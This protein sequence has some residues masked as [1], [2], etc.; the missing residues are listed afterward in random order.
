MKKFVSLTAVLLFVLV[1]MA[2]IA[3]AKS[4]I[5]IT[6]FARVKDFDYPC[7]GVA[8]AC[9]VPAITLQSPVGANGRYTMSG[10]ITVGAPVF[11]CTLTADWSYNIFGYDLLFSGTTT[12]APILIHDLATFNVTSDIYLTW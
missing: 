10:W 8:I 6:G 9:S 2:G 1:G 5:T 12:T 11:S 3:Q 7:D 4:Q